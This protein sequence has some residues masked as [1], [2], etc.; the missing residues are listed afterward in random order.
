MKKEKGANNISLGG[1]KSSKGRGG[2]FLGGKEKRVQHPA[3]F[4]KI[5]DV[6]GGESFLISSAGREEKRR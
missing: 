1:I 6:S 4:L 5:K 3:L 2:I